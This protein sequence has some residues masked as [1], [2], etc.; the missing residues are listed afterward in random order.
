MG[1]DKYLVRENTT[2]QVCLVCY[3][4]KLGCS[5]PVCMLN[6]ATQLDARGSGF[7]DIAQDQHN[8]HI[9]INFCPEASLSRTHHRVEPEVCELVTGVS[10][11]DMFTISTRMSI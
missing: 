9:H 3:I 8:Y 5:G 2:V 11:F 10:I 6:N 7:T 4:L 1:L